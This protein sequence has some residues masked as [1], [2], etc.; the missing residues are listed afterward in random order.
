MFIFNYSLH[1]K[2]CIYGSACF[3]IEDYITNPL[4]IENGYGIAPDLPGIGF[5]FD[6]EK[7]KKYKTN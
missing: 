4:K 2:Y 1:A 7:L 3:G 5:E 6:L